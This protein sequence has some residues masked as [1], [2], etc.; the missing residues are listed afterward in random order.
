MSNTFPFYCADCSFVPA[1]FEDEPRPCPRCGSVE[2]RRGALLVR[3]KPPV[4]MQDVYFNGQFAGVGRL[5]L[6]DQSSGLLSRSF[7]AGPTERD[8]R[9][10]RSFRIKW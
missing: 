1:N 7:T 4:P 3:I 10:L 9:M 8:S 6:G 2:F 5:Q